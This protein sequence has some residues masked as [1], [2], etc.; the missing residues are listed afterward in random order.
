MV[1]DDVDLWL[2]VAGAHS[3]HNDRE[4]ADG[5]LPQPD[6]AAEGAGCAGPVWTAAGPVPRLPLHS[7]GQGRDTGLMVGGVMSFPFS[8]ILTNKLFI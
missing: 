6:G 5:D 7:Q 2:T 8:Q 1:T 4:L 3:D